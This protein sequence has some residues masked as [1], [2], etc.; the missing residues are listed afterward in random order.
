MEI[1]QLLS[2]IEVKKQPFTL[3]DY[4]KEDISEKVP[5]N[6]LGIDAINRFDVL[7][8]RII[9]I[10]KGINSKAVNLM[11]DINNEYESF[12]VKLTDISFIAEMLPYLIKLSNLNDIDEKYI[13]FL[14][15]YRV[16]LVLNSKSITFLNNTINIEYVE[17]VN[18]LIFMYEVSY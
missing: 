13:W 15:C 9:T 7:L 6:L 5:L 1:E 4:Q 10:D 18:E 16:N 3:E 14:I 2:T 17:N 8:E 11:A 12:S